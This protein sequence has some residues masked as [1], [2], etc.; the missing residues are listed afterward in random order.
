VIKPVLAHSQCMVLFEQILRKCLLDYGNSAQ[1][2]YRWNNSSRTGLI[3]SQVSIKF[4]NGFITSWFSWINWMINFPCGVITVGFKTCDS[5]EN[6]AQMHCLILCFNIFS[7][8]Y[9]S[10]WECWYYWGF[11]GLNNNRRILKN[12][13]MNYLNDYL[14]CVLLY[15]MCIEQT[16]KIAWEC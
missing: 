14:Y 2:H 9:K 6:S 4:A 13:T 7:W 10:A 1:G 16:Y 5:S 11:S 15:F 12:R 8:S 3:L